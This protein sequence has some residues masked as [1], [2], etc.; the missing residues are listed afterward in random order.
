MDEL[1]RSYLGSA[2]L[3]RCCRRAYLFCLSFVR[4][5]SLIMNYLSSRRFVEIV[6]LDFLQ[7]ISRSICLHR[8][9]DMVPDDDNAFSSP[10]ICGDFAVIQLTQYIENDFLLLRLSTKSCCSFAMATL[11]SVSAVLPITAIC[12]SWVAHF[13]FSATTESS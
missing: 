6:H 1:L 4:T 7:E 13:T 12:S 11:R 8:A 3:N 9:P 5:S 2:L 10:R